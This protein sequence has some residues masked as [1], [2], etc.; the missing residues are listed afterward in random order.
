MMI[1]N[2]MSNQRS[3]RKENFG[4]TFLRLTAV[5]S[6]TADKKPDTSQ[7]TD[8]DDTDFCASYS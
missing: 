5:G 7:K 4:F 8:L 2:C 3:I 1:I 6:P